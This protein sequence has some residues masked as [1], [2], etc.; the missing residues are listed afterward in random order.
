MEENLVFYKLGLASLGPKVYGIFEGGRIE[1]FIPSRTLS[2]DDLQNPVLRQQFA[3]KLARMHAIRHPIIEIPADMV[4]HIELKLK[5]FKEEDR[6]DLDINPKYI[7]TGIDKQFVASFSFEQEVAWLHK[8]QPLI[9]SRNVNCTK[10]M[11]R[12]N[13]LVRETPDSFNELITLIDYEFVGSAPRASDFAAH[14]AHWMLDLTKPD[15]QGIDLPSEEIR[16]EY[17]VEY[18][19]EL[20]KVAFEKFDEDGLDSLDNLINEVEFYLLV[21]FLF[22]SAWCLSLKAM[23][24][25]APEQDHWFGILRWMSKM[26]RHFKERKA[27]FI[28]K[29]KVG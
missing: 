2:G 23:F 29:H 5:N 14:F 20:K 11:N 22:H 18:L 26:L 3:R 24:E 4:N 9:N 21:S 25:K 15:L 17:C 28:K 16:I 6:Q 7:G 27:A 19:K 13:C 1:E 8:V 10:D 12:L